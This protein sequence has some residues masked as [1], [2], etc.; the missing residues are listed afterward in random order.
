M[1]AVTSV[2][3]TFHRYSRKKLLYLPWIFSDFHF[4]T[5]SMFTTKKIQLLYFCYACHVSKNSQKTINKQINRKILFSSGGYVAVSSVLKIFHLTKVKSLLTHLNFYAV[6]KFSNLF[7][8]YI[9][10]NIQNQT[11]YLY[12]I[13]Q[14]YVYI[15][16]LTDL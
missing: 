2:F 14:I 10:G 5:V 13:M 6:S 15:S 12:N 4:K 16:V 7:N 9:N 8:L 11:R 1:D 3:N